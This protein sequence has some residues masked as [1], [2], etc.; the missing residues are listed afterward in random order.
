MGIGIRFAAKI[1]TKKA[2][3]ALAKKADRFSVK[4]VSGAADKPNKI[5]SNQVVRSVPI[6][7]IEHGE[8]ARPGGKL[9]W[10]GA[11]KTVEK[12]ANKK[13]PFPPIEIVADAEAPG[14]WVVSDGS[15][16]LEAA[17]IRGDTEIPAAVFKEDLENF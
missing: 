7:N 15:H 5:T 1:A 6:E 13:T 12:Y 4:A 14:R 11:Y 17:K 9:T 3:E 16:R 10:P 2:A 8:S